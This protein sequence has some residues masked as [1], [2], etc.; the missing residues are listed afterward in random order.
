MKFH[1]LVPTLGLLAVAAHAADIAV[2]EEI[3]AKVNGDIITLSEIDRTRRALETELK[4]TGVRGDDL[5]KAVRARESDFLRDRID[6]LLL[7]QKGKEL[8]LNVDAELSR[9]LAD[10]QLQS[11]ITDTDKFHDYVREQTGM[12]FEDF[13]AETRN[14]MLTQRVV[15][16]EV[17]SKI[18]VPKSELQ[19]YYEE[20]KRDFMREERVYLREI[21]VS[22]EGKDA[23]GQAAAEKKAKDLSARAKKAE[24]FADLARDNSDNPGTAPQG[25][26]L[27]WAKK[28]ELD[29]KIEDVVF[30]QQRGFVTDPIKI[31][32]GWLILRVEEHQKAG[33][34]T[35]E[36]AEH[37]IT[38]KL[39]SPRMQ[40][41]VREYLTTLR[42]RAFLEIKDGFVDS[43][44]A[45]GKSTKWTDP[46]Q[47]KP[48]T[49][50]KQE[51]AS[52]PRRKR[53]LWA[54]PIP[55]TKRVPKSAVKSN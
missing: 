42:E 25:G 30:A 1:A 6:Q 32:N 34:A 55:G 21:F 13:K 7:V 11:K 53:F 46:A 15:G 47:L 45:P 27:G 22:A 43:G 8:N 41:K 33:Q 2:V 3:I 51:V 40:P 24:K 14:S 17:S 36:E 48:E 28:G 20:H 23:A 9:Y 35:Y 19:K 26:D 50:T 38:D 16:Q 37:E 18:N 52:R 10:L 49:V 39:F 44:S 12:S 5:S 54:I 31:A 29:K 4:R